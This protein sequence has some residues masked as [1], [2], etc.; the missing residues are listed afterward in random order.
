M[1]TIIRGGR[2]I[3]PANKIDEFLPLTIR[4]GRIVAVGERRNARNARNKDGETRSST[5]PG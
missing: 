4:D 3:D 1:I 5:R 2:V